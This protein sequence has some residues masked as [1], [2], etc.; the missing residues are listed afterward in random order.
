MMPRVGVLALQG[1]FQA[2]AAMLA[3]LGA[4]AREVRRPAH[5]DGL[6]GLVLPGGES[7]TMWTFLDALDMGR[8]LC[9]FAQQG[10]ALYGTCAG[11][12]LLAR[13]IRNP[14][15]AGLGLLDITVERNG[16]GRQTDSRIQRVPIVAT[17]AGALHTDGSTDSAAPV[18]I[19][20]IR[21]PRIVR[22]GAA[23]RCR[24]TW[25]GDPL[26]VD[27]D[28]DAH[29]TPHCHQIHFPASEFRTTCPGRNCLD[30]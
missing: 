6:H 9:N 30:G 8:A 19:V 14:D 18:E 12:I 25:N 11:V 24:L 10:G 26:W 28:E 15:R 22:T 4:E 5:L 16:Y 29:L 1:D 20:L 23:V 21:A 13:D 17:E 27:L 3:R 2:H 7:T